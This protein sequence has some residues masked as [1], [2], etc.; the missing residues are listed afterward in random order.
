M[1]TN[2]LCLN[3]DQNRKNETFL[4]RY[5]DVWQ[6]YKEKERKGVAQ[7]LGQWVTEVGGERCMRWD[8][9]V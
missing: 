8:T 2:R 9:Y 7:N 5:V 3:R 1:Y 4:K 6:D